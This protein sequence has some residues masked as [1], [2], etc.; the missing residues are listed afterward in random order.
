MWAFGLRDPLETWMRE[1]AGELPSGGHTP[2]ATP[3][4]SSSPS[5]WFQKSHRAYFDP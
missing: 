2:F 5:L 4:G 3:S 1:L